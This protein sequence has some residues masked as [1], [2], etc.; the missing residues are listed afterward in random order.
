M[1]EYTR[2]FGSHGRTV[3]QVLLTSRDI[4]RRSTYGNAERALVTLLER[5]VVPVI[6]ENDAV[7]TDEIRFGDNDRLAAFVAHLVRADGLVLLTDVDGL[8]TAPPTRPGSVRIA[9][10][11]DS[12]DLEGI[13]VSAR[14]SA[15]G[16]GGMATK[17]HA[18]GLATSS[19]IP[20]LL[21]S[22]NRLAEALDPSIGE[23]EAAQHGTFFHV[24]GERLTGKRMWLGYAAA[25]RGRLLVDPGAAEAVTSGKRSLLPVGVVGVE[26]EF[27]PG[28]VVEVVDPTGMIVARGI[29]GYSSADLAKVKGLSLAAIQDRLGPRQALEA[30]HR[31]ELTPHARSRRPKPHDGSR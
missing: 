29:T 27:T 8:R 17:V 2:A 18:A 11:V 3:G 25:P 23:E 7:A 1:A 26:G 22:V 10:V 19:G 4:V 5:G 20:V 9:E 15:V 14:G 12:E 21:T 28:D 31:D 16:T 6:N 30:I 24:T 13:S